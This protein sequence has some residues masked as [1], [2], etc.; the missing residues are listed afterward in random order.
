LNKIKN[1]PLPVHALGV[2]L[3]ICWLCVFEVAGKIQ[4][5][6]HLSYSTIFHLITSAP[7]VLWKY[8]F[9]LL[10]DKIL[11][12]IKHFIAFFQKQFIISPPICT[13]AYIA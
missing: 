9:L 13:Y 8:T 2:L 4:L 10:G 3:Y 7:V 11:F 6:V 12:E 1:Q 5:L